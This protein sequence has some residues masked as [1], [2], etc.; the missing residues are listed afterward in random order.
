MNRETES[1]KEINWMELLKPDY[2][3]IVLTVVLIIL[4]LA[5]TSYWVYT[6][7][8]NRIR[9]IKSMGYNIGHCRFNLNP[10]ETSFVPEE[11]LPPDFP[12]ASEFESLFEMRMEEKMIFLII[13]AYLSSACFIYY[14]D[15]YR[16]GKLKIKII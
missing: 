3:K 8:L 9:L 5:I 11:Q 10:F 1:W 4:F 13:G 7:C 14:F 6:S 16:R 12:Y 2:R 15:L